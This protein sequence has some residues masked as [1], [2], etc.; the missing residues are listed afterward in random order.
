M[1]VPRG[2]V[3]KQFIERV[4]RLITRLAS[5]TPAARVPSPGE[6]RWCDIG[7]GDCPVRVEEGPVEEG[8]TGDFQ[9]RFRSLG[10]GSS[11]STKT[12]SPE[13]Q[14]P[15]HPS[16][17]FILMNGGDAEARYLARRGPYPSLYVSKLS[18]RRL[19]VPILHAENRLGRFIISFRRGLINRQLPR[20][21]RILLRHGRP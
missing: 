16:R 19:T 11:P 5:E 4:G 1:E 20:I 18:E 3:D 9:M 17:G 10:H 14:T 12:A 2:A 8:L 7:K 6:C 15:G 21:D 13:R